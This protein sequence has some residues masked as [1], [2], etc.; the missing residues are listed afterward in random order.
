MIFRGFDDLSLGLPYTLKGGNPLFSPSNKQT[1]KNSRLRH[2]IGTS[3]RDTPVSISSF[4]PVYR[5]DNN[6]LH[7]LTEEGDGR[8]CTSGLVILD[9]L[10][11]PPPQCVVNPSTETSTRPITV[12]G[13]QT[14]ATIKGRTLVYSRTNYSGRSIPEVTHTLFTSR[15]ITQSQEDNL[16]LKRNFLQTRMTSKVSQNTINPISQKKKKMTKQIQN[17]EQTS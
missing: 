15:R 17:V 12:S 9:V 5:L 7:K 11:L 2:L 10:S 16:F 14:H 8:Q 6:T 13:N 1:N 3:P 4:T